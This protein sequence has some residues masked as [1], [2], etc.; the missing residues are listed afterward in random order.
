M[1]ICKTYLVTYQAYYWDVNKPAEIRQEEIEIGVN[2]DMTIGKIVKALQ[3][4]IKR[5]NIKTAIV[6]NFWEM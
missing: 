5:G 6:I 2:E 1:D 4:N 3:E